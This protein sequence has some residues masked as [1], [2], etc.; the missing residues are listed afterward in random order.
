[1]PELPEVENLRRSL[2][3]VVM[4]QTIKRVLIRW[5]KLVSGRGNIRRASRGA[6]REF[7]RRVKNQKIVGIK[8]RAKNLILILSRGGRIV[9]HLKMSGRFRFVKREAGSAGQITPN[10]HDHIIFELSKGLLIYND[11]RKFGYLIYYPDASAAEG[12]FAGVG[13]EPLS[14]KFTPAYLKNALGLRRGRIKTV[15]MG[16]AV[17]A[18]LGNIYCD[19]ALFSAGIRP[20]RKASSLAP[21]EIRKLHRAIRRV[22]LRAIKLGGSTILTY[23]TMQG[24]RGRYA[25]ELKV[26]GR[27][28]KRCVRCSR[29]LLGT[30]IANRTTVYCPRCQR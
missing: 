29:R 20:T 12:H 3:A 7:A 9:V 18:G 16:Q 26:Y 23:R 25:E 1:M 6:A 10:K 11:T 28:G 17:V 14:S 24:Q 27:A 30:R 2:A 21:G 19:E 22:L 4:G 15:L 5:P 8:R 13:A